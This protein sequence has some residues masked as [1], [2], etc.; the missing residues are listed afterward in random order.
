[1]SNSSIELHD[2]DIEEIKVNKDEIRV[3]FGLVILHVSDGRP[4][5]DAGDVYVQKAELLFEGD[6][7]LRGNINEYPVLISDGT[8]QINEL[9]LE[10]EI[11]VPL[12][13]SGK[14]RLAISPRDI[15]DEI[16]I[17]S[18]RVLLTL[19]DKPKYL[20]AFP[21]RLK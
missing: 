2:S 8:L 15:G 9:I 6:C 21:G 4:G 17:T 12:N 13:R 19:L 10:N 11:P 7:D 20:E 16:T 3:I 5:I 14:V 18:D 1:M